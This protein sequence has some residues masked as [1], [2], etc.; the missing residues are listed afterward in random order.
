MNHLRNKEAHR[1][2][3]VVRQGQE[4]KHNETSKSY[5]TELSTFSETL[6][7]GQGKISTKKTSLEARQKICG[8]YRTQSDDEKLAQGHHL[9]FP[10]WNTLHM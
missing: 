10:T 2:L 6:S 7:R 1:K 4:L 5:W 3:K 9:S 8:V